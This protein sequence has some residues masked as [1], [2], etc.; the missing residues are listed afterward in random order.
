MEVGINHW[1]YGHDQPRGV[2]PALIKQDSAT[3][4]DKVTSDGIELIYQ[5]VISTYQCVAP[6]GL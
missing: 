1:P 5:N 6:L 3:Q 4:L 2:R